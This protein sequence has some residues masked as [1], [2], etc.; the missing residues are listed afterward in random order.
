MPSIL[1]VCTGN[2]CRSPMA[3]ALFRQKIAVR[4]DAASWRIESAG[5]WALEG[6]PAEKLARRILAQRGLDA[7]SHRARVVT[8]QLLQEFDLILVMEAGHKEAICLEFPQVAGRVYMLSEMTDR[9]YDIVDPM[10]GSDMDFEDTANELEKLFEQG[11]ERILGLVGV[12][13]E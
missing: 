13:H 12:S 10:G 4:P 6:R 5:T 8:A 9:Y 11:M 7:R 3:E 2:I 1:F